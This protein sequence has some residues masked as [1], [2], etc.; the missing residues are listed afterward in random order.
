MNVSSY[1]DKI[2]A[3]Q[4][5]VDNL[6]PD[7][8]RYPGI[9]DLFAEL[10]AILTELRPAHGAVEAQRGNQRV[11]VKTRRDLAVRGGQIHRRL[12]ALVAAH[13]GFA[14]PVLVTYGISPENNANRKGRRSKKDLE[15]K[16]AAEAAAA[17]AAAAPTA[18]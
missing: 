2:D 17:A 3:F 1:A 4:T 18:A 9:S 8:P 5:T 12:S 6:E 11:A 14:N 7:V 10:K 13:T 15:A 16:K